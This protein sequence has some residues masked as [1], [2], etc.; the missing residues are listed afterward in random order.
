MINTIVKIL[1][2]VKELCKKA[3][4]N[5][6]I[7]GILTKRIS[8]VIPLIKIIQQKDELFTSHYEDSHNNLRRLILQVPQNMKKYIEEIT[9]YDTMQELLETETF[10]KNL[11][12][13]V[14]NI[15]IL[16]KLVY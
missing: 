7:A 1:D 10:E 4:H 15:M 8:K 13:Y 16:L 12:N 6:K 14:M 5:K 2:E 3:Q 9:Q 11:K